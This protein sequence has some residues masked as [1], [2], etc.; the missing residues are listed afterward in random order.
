MR[1]T[2]WF[3]KRSYDPEQSINYAIEEIEAKAGTQ[4]DPLVVNAFMRCYT[5]YQN[6]PGSPF[7]KEE[8]I[9]S[10]KDPALEEEEI[11]Q[12]LIEMNMFNTTMRPLTTSYKSR[13]AYN[14]SPSQSESEFNFSQQLN[15]TGLVQ[16]SSTAVL[17]EEETNSAYHRNA[18][19][20]R[21]E[22]R[23][24]IDSSL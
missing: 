23:N 8:Q 2:Q 14:I 17:D 6:I 3:Q 19:S 1:M 13:R 15:D 4:F 18:F 5:N 21:I 10:P 12:E 11:L 9:N 20:D 16:K 24:L 22:S 7:F